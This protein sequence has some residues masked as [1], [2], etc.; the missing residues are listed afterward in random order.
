MSTVGACSAEELIL[1]I[2]TD[3]PMDVDASD[4]QVDLIPAQRAGQLH[5]AFLRVA[6]DTQ[7]VPVG[8]EALILK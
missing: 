3:I 4:L 5:Y 2:D 1:R 7:A 8:Q 6:R